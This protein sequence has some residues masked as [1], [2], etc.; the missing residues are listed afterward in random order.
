MDQETADI[1]NARQAELLADKKETRRALA[2]RAAHVECCYSELQ[3]RF[4]ALLKSSAENQQLADGNVAVMKNASDVAVR[5]QDELKAKIKSARDKIDAVIDMDYPVE[6]HT[7]ECPCGEDVETV[8]I[9]SSD[10][11]YRLLNHILNT[12]S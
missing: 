6:H 3:C 4:E 2:G 7:S 8:R 10:P 11:T 5:T 12:L 9:E 1:L